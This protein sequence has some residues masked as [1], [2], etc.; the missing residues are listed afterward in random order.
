VDDAWS[1][2]P[3]EVTRAQEIQ[4][5]QV[6]SRGL[7]PYFVT[8]TNHQEVVRGRAPRHRGVLMG[9]VAEVHTDSV[10]IEPA[11]AH[12]IAPLKEGDGL[13]FDAADWRDPSEPEEGGRVYEASR[14]RDGKLMLRF[15]NRA[16]R[17]DRIRPG[18]LAW[19][20]S[21]AE[22]T[23]AARPFT[24]AAA[25]VRRQ[26]VRVRVTAREGS[27]LVAEWSVVDRPEAS[28]TV[29]SAAPLATAQN[30]GISV[31]SVR[32][33]FNRLGNTPYEL[34]EVSLE[35]EGSPFAPVSILN[36]M[37]R[38][39]VEKLQLLQIQPGSN[40]VRDPFTALDAAR[41][42]AST[43]SATG[44][45]Q[46]HLL[47]RTPEQLDAAIEL[48]PA[49]ITLDYLDL[50]GLRPSVERVKTS[51]ITA[52]VASPRVLKPGESRIVNFLLSLE[53]QIL[54][55]ATGILQAIGQNEHPFLIGDFS[56][57]AANSLAAAEYLK[58]VSR[59]TPTH[60]LN[61]A[62][63][64][65]LAKDAGAENLEVI[66]YQHLPVFHTEHCVFCRFLSSGT[67]YKDCGRPCEKHRVELRDHNGRAHP[68]M[69]DV[70]CRNTVFG[71]EAQEASAHL[72]LWRER[73]IRHFRLEFVHESAGQVW[74]ITRLF[75]LALARQ[76][77]AAQ[78]NRDLKAIAPE[79]TTQGS[80][81]VPPNYLELP[82]LQ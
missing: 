55:R 44:S 27:P 6:Y 59:L 24:E 30:R 17:F 49:S 46:I 78:L 39:A 76:I 38:E 69:A 43:S 50:Y 80:L 22:V 67:S 29:N 31:E 28:V 34:E 70:G 65:D 62:Q 71:A 11:E 7:G 53:C 14:L 52:R 18:D 40:R 13:V 57:N 12:A 32:E 82:I 33:Q 68:L 42:E 74:E 41:T 9:R 36:Q 25:P 26:P 77:N 75:R 37:R 47:V 3:H 63:V 64:A 1:G 61:A 8:G 19:R 81:F 72:D 5:E 60:D 21:N 54:V 20:S 2:R 4:L 10:A 58:L 51:G 66:A 45:P 16:I 23:Q 35:A 15:A 73:G 56:L 79:G 48:A